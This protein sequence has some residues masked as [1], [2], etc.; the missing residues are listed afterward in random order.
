MLWDK[1]VNKVDLHTTAGA[2]LLFSGFL[3]CLVNLYGTDRAGV[4]VKNRFKELAY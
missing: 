2:Y 4:I 1:I 3:L